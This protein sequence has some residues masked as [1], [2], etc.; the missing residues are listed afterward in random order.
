M[1]E[2][3][4]LTITRTDG[5][6]TVRNSNNITLKAHPDLQANPMPVPAAAAIKDGETVK[7]ECLDW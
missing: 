2:C 1:S 4:P 5:I 6:Q 7:I 3:W